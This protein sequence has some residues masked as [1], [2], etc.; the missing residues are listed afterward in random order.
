MRRGGSLVYVV[1]LITVTAV[2][3][4]TFVA[5][6]AAISEYPPLSFLAIRFAIAF[7]AL[8]LLIRSRPSRD[9]VL[10]GSLIGLA[11][12]AGYLFQTLGLRLTSPAN[13]G[14]ITG[15][16]VLFTPILERLAGGRIPARTMVAVG[17]AL[18]GTLLLTAG[19]SRCGA[20]DLLV[21][22]CAVCFAGH[23]VLL[24]RW[25][26][27]LPTGPL[28][29]V[30]MACCGLLFGAAAAP[31]LRPP[32]ADVVP[33]LLLTG[34]V[35]SAAGF[36]VQTR[37][38]SRLSATRTGLVLASEPAWALFFAVLLAGQRLGP[39]QLVGAGLVLAAIM[40]H[41]VAAARASKLGSS[42]WQ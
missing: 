25:S 9:T 33:A 6:K 42:P 29:L 32:P 10:K 13:A 20:G 18:A 5:V 40:G 16:L 35:A 21:L 17:V 3:G 19:P 2:W 38:Q 24:S 1:L 15:L 26:P 39:L 28:A 7:V 23:T 30:Q 41:E 36:W 8:F 11:L 14:L 31:W 22:A 27:G 12:A 34:V 37:A 4:W